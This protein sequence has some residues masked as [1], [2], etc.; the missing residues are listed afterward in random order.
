M[1]KKIEIGIES[2]VTNEIVDLLSYGSYLDESNAVLQFDRSLVMSDSLISKNYAEKLGNYES[3]LMDGTISTDWQSGVNGK[4]D[5]LKI[6]Q[7]EKNDCLKWVP[8]YEPGSYWIQEKQ[9]RLYSDYSY[10]IKADS[11]IVEVEE[12]FEHIDA[13]IWKRD[14]DKIKKPYKYFLNELEHP[15]KKY[16]YRIDGNKILFNREY[17]KRVGSE[18]YADYLWENKGKSIGSKRFLY[19]DFFPIKSDSFEI[20][21]TNG[22]NKIHLKKSNNIY[23]EEVE[24]HYYSVDEDLGVVE[25]G[26][27]EYRSLILDE[28]INALSTKVKVKNSINL[29]SYPN[30]GYI[31]TEYGEVMFYS[32]KGEYCLEG[33][34]YNGRDL[35]EGEEL[36]LRNVNKNLSTDYTYYISYVAVPRIELEFGEDLK[37][38]ANQGL[39]HSERLNLKPSYNINNSGVVQLSTKD[40]HVTT[41]HLRLEGIEE[42][43]ENYYEGLSYGNSFARAIAQALDSEEEGVEGIQIHII[44]ESGPG[45]LNGGKQVTDMS[46]SNGEIESGYYAPYE[47]EDIKKEITNSNHLSSKTIFTVEELPLNLGPEDVQLYE[48]L[49]I[50]HNAGTRGELMYLDSKGHYYVNPDGSN[51]NKAYVKIKKADTI[52][53]DDYYQYSKISIENSSANGWVDEEIE[54]ILEDK[55]YWYLFL[56]NPYSAS[57][58]LNLG[59]RCYIFRK[60]S[61]EWSSNSRIGLNKV[62]Y[63]WNENAM[64]PITREKGA[65]YPLRPSNIIENRVQY[66]TAL[67]EADAY[68]ID[69]ILGDYVILTPGMV[70]M[71]AWCQDPYTGNTIVSN[72][73]R[74]KIDIPRYLNGVNF[75]EALPVPYGFRLRDQV[76]DVSSGV[77]GANFLSI[78]PEVS[79][80]LSLGLNFR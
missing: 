6:S 48:V 62:V 71:Y 55:D 41:L 14:K 26:S 53:F 70:T 51:Y 72:R 36:T 2:T 46:N 54:R 68:D 22:S 73:V 25:I 32:S 78:N 60:N 28:D 35:S 16:V 9:I 39:V 17:E 65:Y 12:D 4:I 59:S 77:G 8:E 19:T 47:W 18:K 45:F 80:K 43:S 33:V 3:C 5:L 49:K 31:L 50:D 66:N 61:L 20:V 27:S 7:Y 40:K 75:N 56:K 58:I 24:D 52:N 64:H 37:R 42:V 23:L 34:V 67:K 79:N 15:N 10:S 29:K 44:I 30:S 76:D 74:A 63:K 38:T 69:E 21:A 11:T 13:A 57:S 1:L